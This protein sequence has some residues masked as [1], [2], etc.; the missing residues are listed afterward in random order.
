[1]HGHALLGVPDMRRRRLC[2]RLDNFLRDHNISFVGVDIGNEIKML[3]HRNLSVQNFV[4]IQ[5]RSK[6][7]GSLNRKDSLADYAASIIDTSYKYMKKNC[8]QTYHNLWA[9]VPLSDKHVQYESIDAYAT[10]EVYMRLLNFEKGQK[11]LVEFLE[12]KANNNNKKKKKKKKEK[13][14]APVH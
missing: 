4:D 2:P 13:E 12:N 1:M 8:T 10:Y 5:T 11:Y 9:Q 3:E 6:P 7:P 14:P